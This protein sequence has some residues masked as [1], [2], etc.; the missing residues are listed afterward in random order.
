MIKKLLLFCLMLSFS[1][2]YHESAHA[3]FTSCRGTIE[4]INIDPKYIHLKIATSRY[5]ATKRCRLPIR[6]LRGFRGSGP[7]V[8]LGTR[9]SAKNIGTPAA[10][11][12]LFQNALANN[13]HILA[14]MTESG[15]CSQL[16][17]FS[18]ALIAREA[19]EENET[20]HDGKSSEG[21]EGQL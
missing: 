16:S 2:L 8:F 1:S 15:Y 13:L 18:A 9:R 14:V 20:P 12:T 21:K 11:M 5:C 6:T 10:V 7:A 17:F 19:K 4:R 3:S